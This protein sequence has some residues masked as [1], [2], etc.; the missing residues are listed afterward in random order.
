MKA[1][2]VEGAGQRPVHTEFEPPSA[3]PGHSLID[4]TA[5]ALSRI[6]QGRAAGTHYSSVGAYPFVVGVDGVGRLDDGRRVYF[7]GAP[8][9]FGAMAERT[10]A[11]DTQ[12]VPLPDALDDVTAAAIAIPGM[13]S[14]AALTERA[15]FVAGETV[16]VNGAT[17][18]SGRLAVRIAKHLGAAKVIATGRNAAAL[19]A[20]LS[21]GA[22][23]AVSLQQ[24]DVHLARAL[25]PHFRAGVDVVLDYLWGAS[26]QALLVV[27]AKATPGGRRLR[28]VEIGSISGADVLLPGA[29]LRATA[30]ELMGSGLGSVPL[31]RL[32]ASVRGVFEAAG[33]AGLAIDTRTVPLSAVGEHWG[34]SSSV[35]R[36]VFT[37]RG[38]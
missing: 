9:P 15:R 16:L 8:A 14:W 11:P 22:D 3:M 37:M 12:C 28:F 13:S 21:A 26:A 10:I 6:A 25:E 23:A 1:A 24:D 2:V 32:L 4:V 7:F 33:E 27:A 35:V 20:L 5:S 34:D 38:E 18:T 19:Q 31:P 17:G 30:I 29:A 36:P